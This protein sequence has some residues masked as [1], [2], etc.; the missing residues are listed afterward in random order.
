MLTSIQALSMHDHGEVQFLYEL[1]TFLCH[2]FISNVVIQRAQSE[3]D[4]TGNN[5]A[6]KWIKEVWQSQ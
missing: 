1:Q 3:E 5:S 4:D 6:L 2:Y